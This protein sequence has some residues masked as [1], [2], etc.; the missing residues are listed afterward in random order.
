MYS[1]F[2]LIDFIKN[3][4]PQLPE[5]IEGIGDD[6]AIISSS[7]LL[8]DLVEVI[9]C[10]TMVENVHFLRT[11]ISPYELGRKAAATN[12]SD[13]AAMGAKPESLILALSIPAG[14]N[15]EYLEELV[16]GVNSW[17]FPLIG[18]DTTKSPEHLVITITA[19]GRAQNNH[20]KRRSG[21]RIGD[22]IYLS[23][24]IGDSAAG[25]HAILNKTDCPTLIHS[26]NNPSPHI[27]I[28]QELAL[29]ENVH[30]MI[31]ISDGIAS[32]ILHILKTSGVGANIDTA[33]LPLSQ[34]FIEYCNTHYI[35]A[36][37][38]A[39]TGGEDYVLLFTASGE[40]KCNHAI[41]P[42]GEITEG[43]TEINW[44]GATISKKGFTHF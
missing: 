14:L 39:T 24:T 23:G 33:K 44:Q 37:E 18:G 8:E 10:D 32:D 29:Q 17:G 26:H 6:C 40:V 1:E 31:D 3:S 38:L 4:Q 22:T 15:N 42:I 28:A 30:S 2:S 41:F 36:L 5:H 7:P 12:L 21:A 16:K 34:D 43:A 19:I 11:A 9:T 27:E 20:V 13:V 25:L 35:N